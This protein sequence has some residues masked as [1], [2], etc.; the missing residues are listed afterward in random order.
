VTDLQTQN[1]N[2]PKFLDTWRDQ[3]TEK[4]GPL[5]TDTRLRLDDGAVTL[6]MMPRAGSTTPAQFSNASVMQIRVVVSWI[7]N[8]RRREVILDS[9]KT[10]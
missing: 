10:Q 1:T 7:E 3:L 2:G 4:T 8:R 6:I 5:T 9:V